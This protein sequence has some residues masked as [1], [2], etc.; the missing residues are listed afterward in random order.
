M[1]DKVKEAGSEVVRAKVREA[2]TERGSGESHR[3]RGRHKERQ[4]RMTL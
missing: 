2:G 3:E 4:L 1:S